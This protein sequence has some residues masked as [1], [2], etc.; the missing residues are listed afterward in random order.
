MKKLSIIISILF[1]TLV[2][3]AQTWEALGPHRLPGGPD[4][5]TSGNGAFFRSLLNQ[6]IPNKYIPQVALAMAM[7]YG[8]AAQISQLGKKKTQAYHLYAETTL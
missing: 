1:A 6:T 7:E 3:Y 2:S 8:K 4:R 5:W